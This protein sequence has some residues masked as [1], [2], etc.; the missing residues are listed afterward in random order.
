MAN[1]SQINGLKITAESASY[2]GTASLL[3]GSVS[4]AI[5]SSYAT[6]ASVS[7]TV[8]SS[9]VTD[10]S[11][12]RVALYDINSQT[13]R[14]TSGINILY[15]PDPGRL[16]VPQITATGITGS[17][18]GSISTATTAATASYVNTLNQN[19]TVNGN[20]T[21]NGTASYTYF[22]ASQLNV[23]NNT[24]SVN[25][26]TP[27]IRFG[28]LLI[29]DSGSTPIATASFLWDSLNNRSIHLRFGK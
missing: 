22:T 11:D 24:I 21:I 14:R 18:S 9:I 25:T 27:A 4:S 5:S 2:A 19:V 23:A 16:S 3:L 29:Y 12:Y 28:G 26:G 8:S 15:A 1:I 6:T 20:L 13:I 17:F 7:L 10:T